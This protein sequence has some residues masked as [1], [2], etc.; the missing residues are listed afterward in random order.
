MTKW[1]LKSWNRLFVRPDLAWAVAQQLAKASRCESSR[2]LVG[3]STRDRSMDLLHRP[4]PEQSPTFGPVR[5][6]DGHATSDPISSARPRRAHFFVVDFLGNERELTGKT[7]TTPLTGP[8]P[9]I[10]VKFVFP[11]SS[12]LRLTGTRPCVCVVNFEDSVQV[13]LVGARRRWRPVG[14]H[15]KS[16]SAGAS[17]VVWGIGYDGTPW[18]YNGG[19]GGGIF[20]QS[21]R[22]CPCLWRFM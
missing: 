3:N 16:I 13:F 19:F 1:D 20:Q 17:G 10:Y 22:K 5:R 18:A 15:L 21:E 11:W 7:V 9:N 12:P 6:R 4:A 2:E 14:G 8:N